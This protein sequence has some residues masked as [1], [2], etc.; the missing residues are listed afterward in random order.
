MLTK[1]PLDSSSFFL[2]LSVT[3]CTVGAAGCS[4]HADGPTEPSDTV[5]TVAFSPSSTLDFRTAVVSCEGDAD[6]IAKL[7]SLCAGAP[8]PTRM[9]NA[10]AGSQLMT[11]AATTGPAL[12]VYAF[13][14]AGVSAETLVWTPSGV[15]YAAFLVLSP[16][17][18]D[19][20]SAWSSG[21]V[22]AGTLGASAI[23]IDACSETWQGGGVL[24]W[25]SVTMT[26][27]WSA[28]KPC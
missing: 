5:A 22:L 13:P 1:R 26:L 27:A 11:A 8:V 20:D 16:P 18:S 14:P 6:D 21:D 17:S 19:A 3:L 24:H 2:T 9:S 23:R 15:R 10:E 7:G 12:L 25:R 28:G 4:S